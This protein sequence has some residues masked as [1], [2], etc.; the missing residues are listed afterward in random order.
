MDRYLAREIETIR[1]MIEMFCK[2]HHGGGHLCE[3]C[4]ELLDY[5][6][7][8]IGRCTFGAAKP[9]CSLCEIHCY[10]KEMRL[11]IKE[12][13]RFSGPRMLYRHPLLAFHHL[14]TLK[15]SSGR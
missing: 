15:G 7:E 14:R 5:A 10:K 2:Y 11:K 4:R 13:M 3:D 8:R 9:A 6:S 12:V 1:V